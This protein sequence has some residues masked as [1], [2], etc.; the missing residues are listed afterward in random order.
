MCYETLRKDVQRTEE[1]GQARVGGRSRMASGGEVIKV[2]RRNIRRK[3][4][5]RKS[6][7][8]PVGE[9]FGHGSHEMVGREKERCLFP[10]PVRAATG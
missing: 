2:S 5:S 10:M 3:E 4:A 9:P 7:S 8:D 6:R 1:S